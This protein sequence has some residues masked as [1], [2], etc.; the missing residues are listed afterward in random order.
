MGYSGLLSSFPNS[1]APHFEHHILHGKSLGQSP[2]SLAVVLLPHTALKIPRPPTGVRMERV[3]SAFADISA[4][5]YPCE[6]ASFLTGFKL[7]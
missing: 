6:L 2:H 5:P 4:V 1:V 3:R 7:F